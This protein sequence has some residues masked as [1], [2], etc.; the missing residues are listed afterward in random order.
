MA[1]VVVI[2][3]SHRL[4]DEVKRSLAKASIRVIDCS[5]V[6]S[7][8]EYAIS[9]HIDLILTAEYLDTLHAKQLLEIR[10]K[11]EQLSLVPVIVVMT[12]DERLP[13]YALGADDVIKMPCDGPE[14]IFRICAA[15][16]RTGT[17]G[18]RGDFTQVGLTDVIQLL[19][20]SCASGAM[21]V[22]ASVIKGT[23]FF[24]NGH[25]IQTRCGEKE[26]EDGFLEILRHCRKDG[27]FSFDAF[28]TSNLRAVITGRTDHLLLSLAN[29]VDEE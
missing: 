18:L 7:A 12:S 6:A 10:R 29:R 17:S 20:S 8:L 19:L 11:S 23:L 3:N 13:Y 27:V 21:R 9:E 15:I 14:I 26:G 1:Q 24:L 16:R 4:L 22:K 28:D 25:V 5:C 2:D